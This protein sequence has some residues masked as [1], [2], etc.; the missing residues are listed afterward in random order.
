MN[1]EILSR[2]QTISLIILFLIGD[3]LIF[4]V[5]RAGKKN[6]WLAIIL[7]GIIT[8]PI[9]LIFTDLYKTFPNK[10]V[11][12][13]NEIIF[14]KY[15]GKL[16][17]SLFLVFVLYKGVF[18]LRS[19]SEFITTVS[20]PETP[21]VIPII[22]TII[23]CIWITKEGI[24]VIGRYSQLYVF[25]LGIFIIISF[26]LII[27]NM[28]IQ[29]MSPIFYI[30]LNSLI[31]GTVSAFTFPFGEIVIIFLVLKSSNTRNFSVSL[32]LKALF[33]TTLSI[34]FISVTQILVLGINSYVYNY[35]PSYETLSRVIIG[36]FLRSI[37]IIVGVSFISAVFVKI[38]FCLYAAA[39]STTSI[40]GFSDYKFVVAPIALMMINFSL[41]MY[42]D[43]MH[44]FE[45]NEKYW[46]YFGL[47]FQILLP[48]L[49]FIVAKLRSKKFN[50]QLAK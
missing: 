19:L 35:F 1:K 42:T 6:L 23:L 2:K 24:E 47:P 15:L 31:K 16:I 32:Y 37:E 25:I 50:N 22:L 14:G 40:L 9:I 12:E 3:V 36:E 4:G 18:V 21:T 13:I 48:I 8:I 44:L 43:L 45:W 39:K 33:L 27:P 7:A 20:F 26:T 17:N 11:L 28:N 30:E 34:F 41:I 29:N 49:I 10:N 5:A 46:F 38:A